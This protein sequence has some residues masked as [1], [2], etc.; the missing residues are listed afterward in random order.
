M[1][2]GA[3]DAGMKCFLPLLF[4]PALVLAQDSQAPAILAPK[5][6]RFDPALDQIVAPDAKLEKL[7]EGFLWS[8]GPVWKDGAFYFSDVPDNKMYRLV[9]GR[10]GAG[11]S[12]AERRC[13]GDAGFQGAGFEWDDRGS[14]E[15]PYHLS[16]KGRGG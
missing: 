12:S 5:I 7:G 14:S 10:E 11:L 8:E 15:A 1:R 9:P 16:S 3:N 4:A 2:G 13:G 6:E